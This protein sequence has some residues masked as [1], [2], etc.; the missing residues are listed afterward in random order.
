V[1]RDTS[2]WYRSLGEQERTGNDDDIGGIFF[3][4]VVL[5]AVRELEPDIDV[6]MISRGDRDDA[7]ARVKAALRG[8]SANS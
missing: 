8:L 6:R 1:R 3:H 2:K 4:S 5:E 7:V